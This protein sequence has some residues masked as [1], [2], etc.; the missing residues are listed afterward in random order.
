[1]AIFMGASNARGEG[2]GRHP[3]NATDPRLDWLVV[4]KPRKKAAVPFFSYEF[5]ALLGE[6]L[7][8]A[9]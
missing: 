4:E 6:V 3:N 9:A 2:S 1:M 7:F 8:A 5:T